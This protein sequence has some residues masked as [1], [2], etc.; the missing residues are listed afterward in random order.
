MTTIWIIVSKLEKNHRK[1][2]RAVVNRLESD[3]LTIIQVDTILYRAA[4]DMRAVKKM[5]EI[6]TKR[7]DISFMRMYNGET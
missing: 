1:S 3:F 4:T 5:S 2:F 6:L 7:V